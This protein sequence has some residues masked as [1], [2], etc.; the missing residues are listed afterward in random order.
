MRKEDWKRLK[1][2]KYEHEILMMR[3]GMSKFR[4]MMNGNVDCKR[5]DI[6]KGLDLVFFDTFIIFH[7]SLNHPA[8]THS[9]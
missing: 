9:I 7:G 4:A 1:G 3:K 5:M 6:G 8:D 2:G